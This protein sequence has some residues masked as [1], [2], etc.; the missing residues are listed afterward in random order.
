MPIRENIE[1]VLERIERAKDRAGT[2]QYVELVAVSKTR[3]SGDIVSAVSA[4]MKHIGENR[5]QEAEK[6]FAE[7]PDL[8]FSRHLLGHLQ[9]NKA[10]KA[11]SVFDWIQSA[12]EQET[13]RKLDRRA[14]EL[15]KKLNVLIEIKTSDEASKTGIDPVKA[16]EFTGRILELPNLV[17]RGYMTIAPFTPDEK[18]VREAFALLRRTAERMRNV[19]R[20]AVLDI[21]SMGM[22]DD[23]E[24]AIAEGSNMVRLGRII[25]GERNYPASE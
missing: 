14:G 5:V 13:C 3:P 1:S 21:L 10:N 8:V 2:K 22:T 17:V 23:F 7:I 25:F 19:Y 18:A 20:D 15:G 9:E 11:A 24:W 12:D 6:K 4:G 16:E